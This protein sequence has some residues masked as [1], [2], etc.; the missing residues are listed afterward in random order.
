MWVGM[1]GSVVS[2]VEVLIERGL[3]GLESSQKR[4]VPRTMGWDVTWE[5]GT[6]DHM[7]LFPL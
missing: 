5:H 7:E 1:N 3:V 6:G 2:Q 4:K